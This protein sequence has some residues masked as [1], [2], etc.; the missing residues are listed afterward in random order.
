MLHFEFSESF[1]LFECAFVNKQ[2]FTSFFQ[3][4]ELKI[5]TFHKKKI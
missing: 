1:G 5:Q 4:S 2:I 3:I